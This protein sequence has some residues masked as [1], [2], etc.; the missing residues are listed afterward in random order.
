LAK[1]LTLLKKRAL[2]IL[3]VDALIYIEYHEKPNLE[4]FEIVKEAKPG[5]VNSALI[6][7]RN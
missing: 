1:S 4:G 6:K 5:F 7:L 2:E 3:A